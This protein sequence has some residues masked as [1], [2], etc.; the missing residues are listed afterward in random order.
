VIEGLC[1][2]LEGTGAHGCFDAVAFNFI[3]GDDQILFRL[4]EVGNC[5]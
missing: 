4:I 1:T 2:G 3:S 5:G